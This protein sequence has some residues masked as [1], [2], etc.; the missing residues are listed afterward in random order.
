MNSTE[1]LGWFQDL[2]RRMPVRQQAP[3]DYV[4]CWLAEAKSAVEAV[5]PP[6]HACRRAWERMESQTPAIMFPTEL[7]SVFQ[8]VHRLLKDGRLGSLIDAVRAETEGELLDQ[9][10]ELFRTGALVAATVVAGGA[11]ET[12]LRRLVAR[13]GLTI[14]GDGSISR[15]NDA[16][17]QARNG[18]QTVG[19]T[20]SDSKQVTYWGDVR[21]V[22]AHKPL[23][24]TKSEKE[25]ELM[26]HGIRSFISRTM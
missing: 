13:Y 4:Q 6:G 2:E 22:A 19:I 24:F 12:H 18:G 3:Y 16:I 17:S 1:I 8:A 23:E 10:D 5:L 26:I 20:S 9:A 25:V 14:K 11:L 21:N 7:V 15:Y